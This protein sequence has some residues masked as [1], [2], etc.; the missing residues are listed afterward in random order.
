VTPKFATPACSDGTTTQERNGVTIAFNGCVASGATINGMLDV[1][2]NRSASAQTCS[3]TTTITLGITTTITNLTISGP[4]GKLVIPSETDMAMTSYAFGQSPAMLSVNTT[5]ELQLFNAQG[6]MLADHTYTGTRTFNFSGN[7][8]YKF[9]S[10]LTVQEKNGPA[11]ATIT[12]TD[13]TRSAGCCRPTAGTVNIDRTGGQLPGTAT[14][15]FGPSCGT[16]MRNAVTVTLPAC[17]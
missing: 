1:L 4:N 3:S 16:V 14:W 7:Q 17:E 2:S 9:S 13:V 11:M 6:S 15:T 10:M 5:G 8:S 12:S